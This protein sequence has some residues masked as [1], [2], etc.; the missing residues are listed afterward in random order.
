MLI[1][2]TF[3]MG[4][5][6]SAFSQF[7]G[8]ISYSIEYSTDDDHLQSMLESF[9]K[10]SK[11]FLKGN[12]SKFEQNTAGGGSQSFISNHSSGDMTLVMQFLGSAFK[13]RV[14]SDNIQELK[15]VPTK[16]IFYDGQSR[17]IGG[18]TCQHAYTIENSDTLHI[19]YTESITSGNIIPE[20]A[21]LEGTPLYYE[22]IKK[23]IKMTYSAKA[24]DE[25]TIA[26]VEF[27]IPSNI[28]ELPF[29]D[30]AR[31]FAVVK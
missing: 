19:Y 17:V 15:Q 8:V 4:V 29:N 1:A 20:L 6:L 22:T 28:R 31:S 27:D 5:S 10:T 3:C 16:E 11:L 14:S 18:I 21:N 24:I 7:E 25:M 26:D 30:F 12:M 13:V 23:D 9:P 2:L